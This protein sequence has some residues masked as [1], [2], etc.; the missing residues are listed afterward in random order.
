MSLT[1]VM[2]HGDVEGNWY[3]KQMKSHNLVVVK[4]FPGLRRAVHLLRESFFFILLC[5]CFQTERSWEGL[6]RLY[7][8]SLL[9]FGSNEN[10][11]F[12]L[13]LSLCSLSSHLFTSSLFHSSVWISDSRGGYKLILYHFKS[14]SSSLRSAARATPPSPEQKRPHTPYS[15]F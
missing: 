2:S 4:T 11:S 10:F 5:S 13:S 15:S 14:C 9:V 1:T 8:E 12:L 3:Q 6:L 7:D